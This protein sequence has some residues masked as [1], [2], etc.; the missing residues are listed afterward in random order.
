MMRSSKLLFSL[1]KSSLVKEYAPVI[2]RLQSTSAQPAAAAA[3]GNKTRK[4]RSMNKAVKPS[5]SFVMNM[6]RGATVTDQVIP[7]PNVLTE[8][9]METLEMLVDPTE[10]FFQGRKEENL[11]I[12]RY[13]DFF[14]LILKGRI[15]GGKRF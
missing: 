13:D 5:Q 4:E 6:F 3:A 12:R 8:D 10:K 2:T 9:Q 11:R 14:L 1:P 15:G 7:Y